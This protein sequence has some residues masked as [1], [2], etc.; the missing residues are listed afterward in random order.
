MPGQDE[1]GCATHALKESCTILPTH[2]PL[3][4][5]HPAAILKLFLVTACLFIVP[6]LQAREVKVGV[7][8][9]PPKVFLDQG[10]KP[11]GIM[12]DLLV[13]VAENENWSLQFVPCVWADCLSLVERGEIDLLPD[14]AFSEARNVYLDFHRTPSLYSWSL[15]FTRADI[16]IE[17]LF[18]LKGKRIAALQGSVQ[19][20]Y[21]LRL[22][23]D[24]GIDVTL[25][26]TPTLAEAFRLV[27]ARQADVAIANK[28]FGDYASASYGLL[29]STIAFQ[30]T[31]L[32]Y[33]TA[34]GN[35]ADLLSAIDKNLQQWQG[36]PG[37]FYFETLRNWQDVRRRRVPV[38][39][40]W[41]LAGTGG[42]LLVALGAAGYLR[43]EVASRTQQLEKNA[44]SLRIAATVFQSQEA[45]FVAGPDRKIIEVNDAFARLTGYCATELPQQTLPS[46]TLEDTGVDEREN[47]WSAVNREGR[48]QAEV[49]T[50]KRCGDHY[51]AW[52]AISAVR[53]PTGEITHYVGTQADITER[54]LLQEQAARLA[55]YDALTNL[56]NRRLLIDRLE[57]CAAV[58]ARSRQISALVFIDLD[59]FKDLNDTLGHEVGDQFLQQVAQRL[60]HASRHA[61]TVARLGGDEFVIL[62][63]QMGT[64][65]NE[66][67]FQSKVAA[68]KILKAV[69][70]PYDLT[71]LSHH[72]SCSIGVVLIGEQRL[73]AQDLLRRGDLAM[74][75][76]KKDGRDTVRFF[77]IELERALTFRT[78]LELELRA[79]IAAE[80]FVL[81][82]Q[83]QFD[84]ANRMIGVEAL[85]RWRHPQRGLVSPGLFIPV[86]EA[87]GL[88]LEMG[89]WVMRSACRQI[90]AW[91]Q[92]PST[93]GLQVA[94]NVSARQ[95][96][97][98]E[99]VT[100]VLAVLEENAVEPS[101]LK[102]ELTESMLVED[103]EETIQKIQLLKD[104]GITLA[105]DDF[106]TGYSSLSYLKRIPIDQLKI[107]QSFI[108]DILGNPSDA[109]I[110]KSVIAL[111]QAFNLDIIAEGV[112]TIAQRDFLAEIGC[113]NYQGYLFARPG[114]A[115]DIEKLLQ[116][117][118]G[119]FLSEPR[120]NGIDA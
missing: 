34:K 6:C 116:D 88:I 102:I 42:L 96:R 114:P 32:F 80:Q 91:G 28:S 17:S 48:W 105:L 35:N 61:D 71:G 104:Y 46:F 69:K 11:S 22:L 72:A 77:R 13:K 112:E 40:W 31:K 111:G 43:R 4:T 5:M 63:E 12:I 115:G 33:A 7:Y 99:F 57:H 81:H 92:N 93:A 16:S 87:S 119:N 82:Y 10:Q 18:D 9:N 107:D 50:R 19:Q 39:V 59:N 101:R 62:M 2:W 64:T 14:V 25:I 70:L 58:A 98:P 66:A 118:D 90:A 76:A 79:A 60:V 15:L 52:L 55:F 108:R 37:S 3:S 94:V 36:N 45:M 97:Q 89:D 27:K 110:A 103:M 68:E 120:D 23:E 109:A 21:F 49:W 83:P 29:G 54:K 78:G 26:P 51:A 44:Q 113:T 85:L 20:H 38:S 24:S 8:E 30:P 47:M 53:L 95:F 106:G 41:G 84:L 56:P 86:A 74:Y 73:S 75:Q 67:M 100:W 1:M 117:G 65:E